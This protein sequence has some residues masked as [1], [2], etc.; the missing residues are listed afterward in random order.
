MMPMPRNRCL[1]RPI[2]LVADAGLVDEHDDFKKHWRSVES[3]FQ[4]VHGRE[5]TKFVQ[6]AQH[7]PAS[8]TES[9]AKSF[10]TQSIPALAEHA[11][12]GT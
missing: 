4:P 12:S 6:A 2:T 7:A 5:A 11:V 3:H 10:P 8:A 1:V 9:T